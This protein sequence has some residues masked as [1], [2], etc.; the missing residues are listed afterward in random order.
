MRR[1][2]SIDRYKKIVD[3]VRS[4]RR[5]IALTTDIIVGFPGETDMD[6]EDTIKLVQYCGFDSSYIFKYSPRP[7]TPAYEMIDDVSP[8]EKTRRFRELESIQ[9]QIQSANLKRYLGRTLKVL[10]EKRSAKS[11]NDLTGH[12]TC[13][14]VVNFAGD[15]N[16]LGKLVEVKITE[17]KS[18]SLYGKGVTTA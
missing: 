2:H 14:R 5:D 11:E 3:K 16:L 10:A 17:V 1:L 15:P 9:K 8:A 12:S 6:F 18:N 7:G 4:S 13:H